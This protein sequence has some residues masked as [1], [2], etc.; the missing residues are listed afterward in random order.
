MDFVTY[1]INY[2]KRTI[3]IQLLDIVTTTKDIQVGTIESRV[4]D[5]ILRPIPLLDLS[6]LSG[7][8]IVIPLG[9]LPRQNV[10]EQ[11]LVEIPLRA[12]NNRRVISVLNL[13]SGGFEYPQYFSDR[14]SHDMA[15]LNNAFRMYNTET[16][17]RLDRV[18]TNE[19]L[20][21]DKISNFN[22][23]GV[24]V[25]VEYSSRFNEINPRS[26]P[27][28][29]ELSILPATQM[30]IHTNMPLKIEE[31][32]LYYGHSL[33]SLQRVV[34]SFSDA[35]KEYYENMNRVRK[36]LFMNDA[37]SMHRYIQHYIPSNL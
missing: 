37:E 12:T 7:V 20:I 31:A 1:A 34:D 24:R 6:I 16:R 11:L 13:V 17:V 9:S 27:S 28:V 36:I 14:L 10:G 4:E 19:F 32:R 30:Y 33:E 29:C 35:H 8:E 2:V 26:Y 5:I 18:S 25:V 3:P 22:D 21:L 23:Y 15:V